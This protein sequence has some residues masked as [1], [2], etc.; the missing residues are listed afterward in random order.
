M[1]PLGQDP[2][3]LC[4]LAHPI[5]PM[6]HALCHWFRQEKKALVLRPFFTSLILGAAAFADTIAPAF[7]CSNEPGWY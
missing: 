6:C 5:R 3:P 2:S 7:D 4:H 1:G